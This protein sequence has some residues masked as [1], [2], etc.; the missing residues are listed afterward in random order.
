MMAELAFLGELFLL[1]IVH[2]SR[3]K[4][5]KCQENNEIFTNQSKSSIWTV[6]D[7]CIVKRWEEK[8]KM[9]YMYC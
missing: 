2:M 8:K 9:R 3:L 1:G 6:R 5:G 4:K 7:L